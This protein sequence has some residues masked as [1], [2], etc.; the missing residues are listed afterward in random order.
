LAVWKLASGRAAKPELGASARDIRFVSR[1]K[2]T[3]DLFELENQPWSPF[4][5]TDNGTI[6]KVTRVVPTAAWFGEFLKG[7]SPISGKSSVSRTYDCCC[8][9]G[10]DDLHDLSYFLWFQ[11]AI[12]A[13]LITRESLAPLCGQQN[14]I[15]GYRI[16]GLSFDL[17]G[18]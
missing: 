10:H 3:P 17:S 18:L 9:S 7:N 11:G 12:Y 2:S 8:D 15:A 4:G 5:E 14:N 13:L 6:A 1:A 16:V